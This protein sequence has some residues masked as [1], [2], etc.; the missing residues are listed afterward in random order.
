M[1]YCVSVCCGFKQMVWYISFVDMV[2]WTTKHSYK[3]TLPQII[4]QRVNL[5]CQYGYCL[6]K[7]IMM[8]FLL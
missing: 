7:F 1:N 6:L 2:H 3:E 8:Q 5:Y 4:G